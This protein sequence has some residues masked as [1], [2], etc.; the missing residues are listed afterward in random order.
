MHHTT[1][2]HFIHVLLG[3]RLLLLLAGL[4][5]AAGQVQAVVAAALYMAAM[6]PSLLRD[7][8]MCSSAAC[9]CMSAEPR[10]V[11]YCDLFP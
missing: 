11:S 5:R 3:G 1:L 8:N 4:L 7:S 9:V 10:C 6:W 2:H